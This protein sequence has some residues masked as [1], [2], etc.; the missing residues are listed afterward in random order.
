MQQKKVS[1]SSYLPNWC[2]S[3]GTEAKSANQSR[4]QLV[5]HQVETGYCAG[6]AFASQVRQAVHICAEMRDNAK[7][8]LGVREKRAAN[9]A[10]SLQPCIELNVT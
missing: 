10:R 2:T 9:A 1:S 4:Q 3:P 7:A 8:K 6:D 5:L